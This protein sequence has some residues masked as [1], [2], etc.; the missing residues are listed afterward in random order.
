MKTKYIFIFS[1]L[2]AVPLIYSCGNA[3]NKKIKQ[4][5]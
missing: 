3:G 1:F 5:Q 4:T 2:L